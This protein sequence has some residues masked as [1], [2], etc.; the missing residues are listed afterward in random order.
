M[1]KKKAISKKPKVKLRMVSIPSKEYDVVNKYADL[2][3]EC[4]ALLESNKKLT[5]DLKASQDAGL[6]AEEKLAESE[7]VVGRLRSDIEAMRGELSRMEGELVKANSSI[8][9]LM[10][11]Y[12]DE[13]PRHLIIRNSKFKAY[14]GNP[15]TSFAVL[16]ENLSLYELTLRISDSELRE[17]AL[18]LVKEALKANPRNETWLAMLQ[19]RVVDILIKQENLKEL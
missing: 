15:E 12:S 18:P 14:T 8:K 11:Q 16:A 5:E 10:G 4:D 9:S 6:K 3:K 13:K 2:R 19:D 1:K 7:K 17:K